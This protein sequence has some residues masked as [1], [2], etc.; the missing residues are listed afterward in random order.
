MGFWPDFT[1]PTGYHNRVIYGVSW[2]HQTGLIASACGDNFI[3]LFKQV[4][5]CCA[6]SPCSDSSSLQTST[7]T[8]SRR[9]ASFEL[10]GSQEAHSQD[11]NALAWQPARPDPLLASCS[12]DGTMCLWRVVPK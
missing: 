6:F 1:E 10:V 8:E 4:G 3:R 9:Q 2:C 5:G 12:D 7:P 11:V